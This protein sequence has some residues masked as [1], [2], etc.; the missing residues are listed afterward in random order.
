MMY[1]METHKYDDAINNR[2]SY[3][4][5]TNSTYDRG[6]DEINENVFFREL[7]IEP[8][9]RRTR[10]EPRPRNDPRN[11]PRNEPTVVE[12]D[13]SSEDED[14]PIIIHTSDSDSELEERADDTYDD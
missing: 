8:P 10:R 1:Y 13:D 7:N 5:D 14:E 3:M 4:G 6:Y 2:Y 12:P 11:D 9:Y